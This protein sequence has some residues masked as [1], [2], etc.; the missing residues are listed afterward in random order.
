M[1]KVFFSI[2]VF[3]SCLTSL[4][5]LAQG[6][7]KD[8]LGLPGDNLNLYGVLD[9]FQQS[10]TLEEFE[11]KLNAQDSKI[12]NLD[13]NGDNKIDYIKV[14]DNV[15]GNSHAI[16]LKDEIS[17]KDL[18]DVAVIEV[19]KDK[20]GK[21]KIQ[22]V[23]DEA[24]YGK[25]YIVE[26]KDMEDKSVSS[27]GTPN[28]GYSGQTNQTTVIN[29]TTNN[30][31]DN[32]NYYP[33]NNYNTVYYPVNTWYMWDFLFAPTYVVYVSPWHWGYY[34]TYWN[35]WVPMYW[36]EYYGYHYH[37]YGYYHRAYEYRS[38]DTHGFYGHRRTV[39][40]TVHHRESEG[41]YHST[42]GHRDMLNK[43][44][45]E[46]RVIRD[47]NNQQGRD[48][49]RNNGQPNRNDQRN[50]PGQGRDNHRNDNQQQNNRPE[51]NNPPQGRDDHRNDNQQQQNNRPERNNPPQGRD[52]HRNDNQQPQQQ[53]RQ[54]RNNPPQNNTHESRPERNNQQARPSRSERREA[55]QV[56]RSE[57]HSQAQPRS[58]SRGNN[59]GNSGNS[60]GGGGR[61]R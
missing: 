46:N 61:K 54:E 41:A 49:H 20:N 34:P 25:N 60:G 45:N 16:V 58:E 42:Y 6:Q 12:N 39:S 7:I 33:H 19:E 9:I 22:I 23:G 51:R 59:S 38:P 2:A 4:P 27:G 26:P 21:V 14:V 32:D 50:N 29:N 47:N 48:E 56:Q 43:S 13:L 18:Q 44:I 8:S 1:K 17:E 55:R 57:Q 15:Q 35:P 30:Y 40:E 36:H 3:G 24:L 53:N 5:A 37:H 52:D 10:K 31:Y 28:P 11:G